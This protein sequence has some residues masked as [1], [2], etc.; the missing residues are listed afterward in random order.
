MHVYTGKDMLIRINT[1][2]PKHMLTYCTMLKRIAMDTQTHTHVA[3]RLVTHVEV[4][5]YR[6]GMN[7]VITEMT[8]CLITSNILLKYI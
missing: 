8:Y 6:T 7:D 4:F 1:K 2:V 5:L 3:A